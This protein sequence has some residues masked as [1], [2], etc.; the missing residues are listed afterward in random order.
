MQL[1]SRFVS[2][3][4]YWLS[5]D[6]FFFWGNEYKFGIN[7]GL[8]VY[9]IDIVTARK[10]VGLVCADYKGANARVIESGQNGDDT[11]VE[12]EIDSDQSNVKTEKVKYFDFCVF[13]CAVL[14]NIHMGHGVVLLLLF[15]DAIADERKKMW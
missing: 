9:E 3:L 13:F 14:C 10:G 11:S 7:C 12:D 6:F 1:C 5:F 15:F 4:F 8:F 2:I